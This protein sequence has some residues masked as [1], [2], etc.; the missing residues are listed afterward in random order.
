M[1]TMGD[2]RGHQAP[3]DRSMGRAISSSSDITRAAIEQPGEAPSGDREG[4]GQGVEALAGIDA[5]SAPAK[6]LCA[7]V[8]GEGR[9]A[10]LQRAEGAARRSLRIC[11]DRQAGRGRGDLPRP[12]RNPPKTCAAHR[13]VRF[14]AGQARAAK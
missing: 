8:R 2:Q 3:S 9:G 4:E 10:Q 14:Y 5:P 13:R 1:A 6:P 7:A 12:A 11:K